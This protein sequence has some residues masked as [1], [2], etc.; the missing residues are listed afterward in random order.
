[1]ILYFL[2]DDF[3]VNLIS[4][5]IYTIMFYIKIEKM[6]YF[7]MFYYFAGWDKLIQ[8]QKGER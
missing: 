3:Y 7:F 8:W 6:E 5:K 4:I 2:V 1:M